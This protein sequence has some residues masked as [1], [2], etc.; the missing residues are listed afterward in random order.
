MSQ[1]RLF[2]ALSRSSGRAARRLR[3]TPKITSFQ[4]GEALGKPTAQRGPK[5]TLPDN[6]S[7]RGAI[8]FCVSLG[9]SRLKRKNC[10]ELC[11]PPAPSPPRKVFGSSGEGR[12]GTEPVE[13]R[14]K[15]LSHAVYPLK[16][17]GGYR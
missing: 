15:A 7:K 9:A 14:T 16:G 11:T 4:G 13:K 8:C 3:G 10:T 1:K 2:N 17:V 5:G 12:E 6:K